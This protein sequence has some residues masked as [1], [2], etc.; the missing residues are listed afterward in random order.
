[1]K[2]Q[3]LEFKQNGLWS[4]GRFL[5]CVAAILISLGLAAVCPAVTLDGTSRSYLQ[6]RESTGG[7]GFL[8]GFEYLDLVARDVGSEEISAHF[9]GWGRYDFREETGD[10]DVQYAFLSYKRK[11]DNSVVNAGRVLVF[12]G[13]ANAER[14]DGLYA[15]TDLTG[16]FGI[17]AFG[18]KPAE[19]GIE[20]P[21]NN[22]I[23]GA[24]IFYQQPNLYGIGISTLKEEK[25]SDSFRNE[26]G[27]D[28]WYRP[29]NKIELLGR[30]S[31]NSLEDD[32]TEHSYNLILGPFDKIKLNTELAYYDYDDF[33][34]TVSTSA[35][36]FTSGIFN[37]SDTAKIIGE[38]VSYSASDKLTV[39]VNVRSFRYN[40]AGD[41]WSYGARANYSEGREK[42]A[43][44]SVHRVSGDEERLRYIQYRL[45]A[46]Q[47]IGR[48]N[49]AVDLID[50]TFDENIGG[51]DNSYSAT[52]A[53][54]YALTE[55]L[56]AG[57]DLE[58]Q[59]N[60]FFD[61]EVKAFAKILYTFGAKAGGGA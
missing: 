19:V 59:K 43:G 21:G 37:F 10:T 1:M 16:G 18:G 51:T 7:T 47:T 61:R 12:E 4:P 55:S 36:S 17:S 22:I 58:Y 3:P 56:R 23:Y 15:R 34:R 44:I 14:V 38:E 46:A 13:V 30:S 20:T 33:L 9:G 41:A 31:Y 50:L 24:R 57:A 39:H 35:L 49:V 28:L 54:L 29:R 26:Q 32:W 25:N 60:P 11:Y 45:Y 2:R 8:P 27:I 48:M 40:I 6:A 5:S 52:I 53:A 42:A